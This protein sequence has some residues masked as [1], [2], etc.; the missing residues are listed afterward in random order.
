M[1]PWKYSFQHLAKNF[2]QYFLMDGKK[3]GKALHISLY[4]VHLVFTNSG[5]L[6]PR[7]VTMNVDLFSGL[8]LPMAYPIR[9][10]QTSYS[11]IHIL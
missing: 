1:L 6:L 3:N 5:K 10:Y 8:H 7:S 4:F 9:I 2:F 11:Q